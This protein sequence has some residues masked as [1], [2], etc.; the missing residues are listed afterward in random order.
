MLSADGYGPMSKVSWPQNRKS[1]ALLLLICSLTAGCN[2]RGL[3]YEFLSLDNYG[4]GEVHNRPADKE[5]SAF[6]TFDETSQPTMEFFA[7]GCA[8]SGNEGQRLL[9]GSM[10][11]IAADHPVDF[12]LYLGDNFYGRGVSSV[13]DLQWKSKFEEIYHHDSLQMPFYAVLGNHDYYKNPEAQIEYSNQS[14]RWRMPNRYYS[15]V[16][17]LKDG[18][19]IE[20]FALDTVAIVGGK[21]QEQLL[22]LKEKLTAS[23]AEWKIVYGHH[24]VYSG[25]ET[26]E[27]ETRVM[28]KIVEPVLIE[29]GVDLYLSAHNHSIE[30][31]EN[32]SGVT[33]VVSGA[34]SRPRD[35]YWTD[36]TDFAYANLGFVW[37]RITSDQLNIYVVNQE[38]QLLYKY[39]K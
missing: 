3:H 1:I 16:K 8:G 7:V 22:W 33:Y 9:A 5:T 38:S 14:K 17:A 15:F 27:A 32:I 21:G 34:G 13:D 35:V 10:A 20:F 19:E 2:M 26:W 28:Q 24:P 23:K 4:A 30:I 31:F 39:T 37:T 11:R 29:T 25:A 12:V 6:V 36:E 18:V